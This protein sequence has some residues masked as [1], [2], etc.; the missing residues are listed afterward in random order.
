MKIAKIL[1][2][3]TVLAIG[4]EGV[5]A[6][7]SIYVSAS[8]A[9]ILYSG[10]ISRKNPES[11][12]FTYP[13]VSAEFLFEGSKVGMNVK[14]GSGYFMVEI[15]DELPFKIHFAE[16]DSVMMLAE[17][18]DYGRHRVKVVYAVEGYDF[19][20]EFRGFFIDAKGKMLPPPARSDRKIE[21]I[22][23]SMMCGYGIEADNG[24]EDFS[25]ATENHYYSFVAQAAR[26]LHADYN[27][28]LRSGYGVYRNYGGPRSGSDNC[29]P[30]LYD[31]TLF[32]DAEEKW[33]FADFQPDVVCVNLGTNDM[34]LDDYDLSLLKDAYFKFIKRLR[35]YYPDA[36]IVMLTGCML[37]GKRLED[38]KNALDEVVSAV[39]AA[40]DDNVYRFDMSPQT[41]ALG[42]GADFH[43]SRR[44]ANKM[45]KELSTYLTKITGW[46]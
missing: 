42:Y 40:G 3:L 39:N 37:W 24:N 18:L 28:V 46:R 7:D 5:S 29:I 33:N 34:S 41:G 14:P 45:A 22:G 43:P 35:G 19:K 10:R 32:Y 44:Q 6:N 9:N 11:L 16:N 25:F 4:I 38:V 12:A 30:N 2:M 17:G 15:D 13:G 21:F 26:M 20:P 8:D 27:A 31:R 36:K 23:N 1:M